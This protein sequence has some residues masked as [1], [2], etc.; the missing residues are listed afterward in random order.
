MEYIKEHNF[1]V[2]V[3]VMLLCERNVVNCCFVVGWEIM[4]FMNKGIS[5]IK[6]KG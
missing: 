1:L 3:A 5:E 4:M 2:F 6:I